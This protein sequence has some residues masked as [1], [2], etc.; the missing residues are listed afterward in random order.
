MIKENVLNKIKSIVG[1]KNFLITLNM[2]PLYF[3]CVNMIINE[4]MFL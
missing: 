3:Y 2:Y 4:N 1:E